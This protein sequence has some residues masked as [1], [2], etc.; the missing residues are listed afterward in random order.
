MIVCPT[1]GNKRCPHA[2]DHRYECTQSNEPGQPGSVYALRGDATTPT[3]A[4]QTPDWAD[5][6]AERVMRSWRILPE[7]GW[8][9]LARDIAA[10]LRLVAIGRD[11]AAEQ[12]GRASVLADDAALNACIEGR[13]AAERE[14]GRKAAS[15]RIAELE[16]FV[17]STKLRALYIAA[18]V[19]DAKADAEALLRE[20]REVEP[21]PD[22]TSGG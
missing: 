17:R 10:S 4:E 13:L 20:C 6:E 22:G 16:L 9:G 1:C 15:E 8:H 18:Y 3:A 2:S 14:R 12:R 21:T 11:T 19:P 7:N 5:R